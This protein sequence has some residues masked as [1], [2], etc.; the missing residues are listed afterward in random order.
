MGKLKDAKRYLQENFDE[1]NSVAKER[2]QARFYH[3]WAVLSGS[4]NPN[5]PD[6]ID[7]SN[8]YV[9]LESMLCDT[10]LWMRLSDPKT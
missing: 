2:L 3:R 9:R 5:D 1:V 8:K 4:D 7:W 10:G 6:T